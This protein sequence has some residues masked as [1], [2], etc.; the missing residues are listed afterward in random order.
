MPPNVNT[1]R[2]YNLPVKVIFRGHKYS[3]LTR[4]T[5]RASNL[6]V[7]VIFYSTLTSA[8]IPPFVNLLFT[9]TKGT[10]PNHHMVQWCPPNTIDVPT[11]QMHPNFTMVKQVPGLNCCCIITTILVDNLITWSFTSGFTSEF[12]SHRDFSSCLHC[13][14]KLT[15][16]CSIT[17]HTLHSAALLLTDF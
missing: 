11:I 2:A 6:P 17:S 8:N 7:K 3:S 15:W 16:S 14:S 1:L 4:Y 10:W 5:L 9:K 12:V 13:N